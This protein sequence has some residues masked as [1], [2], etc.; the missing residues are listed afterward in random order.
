MTPD[1][2][3]DLGRN[4]LYIA[5]LISAPMLLSAFAIGMLMGIL[6]VATQ[7]NEIAISFIPKL[8]VVV[9][10]LMIAG[11]WMLSTLVQFTRRLIEG[12][13]GMIS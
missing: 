7:L 4:T 5:M 11:P 1:S 9:L 13:P 10:V 3:I 8:I 12:L 2:V 6:Q